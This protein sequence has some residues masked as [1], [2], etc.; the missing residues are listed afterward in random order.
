VG[1]RLET[2]SPDPDRTAQVLPVFEP[3]Q[4]AMMAKLLSAPQ[5]L[6]HE[7]LWLAPAEPGNKAMSAATT[8][9]TQALFLITTTSLRYPSFYLDMRCLV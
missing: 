7:P 8:A 9:A 2:L 6:L 1:N 3:V 5:S 4:S